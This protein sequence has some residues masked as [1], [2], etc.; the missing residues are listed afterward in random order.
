MAELVLH[1]FKE[2]LGE[3]GGVMVGEAELFSL[4]DPAVGFVDAPPPPLAL[5]E[6]ADVE[7]VADD[8]GHGVAVPHLGGSGLD[9]GGVPALV[10]QPL[11]LEL[12]AGGIAVLGEVGGNFAVAP[13]LQVEPVDEAH[14]LGAFRVHAQFPLAHRVQVVAIGRRTDPGPFGLSGL[15]DGPDLFAGVG[16]RH[17]VHEEAELDVEPV[18]PGGVIHP[19]ADGDDAHPLV[20]QHLQLVEPQG[21]AAGEAGEI[22]D[23][24]DVVGPGPEGGAEAAVAL[25]LVEGIAGAVPVCKEGEGAFGEGAADVVPDHVLLVFDG[26]VFLIRFL[27]HGD[28]AV[29]GD[30][31]RVHTRESCRRRRAVTWGRRGS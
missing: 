12:E 27:I 11:G 14:H 29:A 30:D 17:F 3:D 22:L 1:L 16:H 2:V 5:P 28:A 23:D 6:G 19:V 15:D 9:P 24:E 10:F 13:A 8:V 21:V 31:G 26:G 7:I 25:P 18:V 4:G 20:P